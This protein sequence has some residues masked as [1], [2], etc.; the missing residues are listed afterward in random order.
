MAPKDQKEKKQSNLVPK[1]KFF[2]KDK[3]AAYYN[4]DGVPLYVGEEDEKSFLKL[5]NIMQ[6]RDGKN[7]EW[8]WRF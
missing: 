7:E 1:Y 4:E 6:T 2:A 8:F 3:L 5:E